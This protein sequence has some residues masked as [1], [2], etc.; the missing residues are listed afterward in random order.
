MID[1]AKDINK[2]LSFALE[3]AMLAGLCYWGFYVGRVWWTGLILGVVIPVL[4]MT[5]WGI[6]LAPKAKRRLKP[7]PGSIASFVLFIVSAAAL[8]NSGLRLAALIVALA[9]A[10]N[11][12]LK[13]A[14]RQW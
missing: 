6:L 7:V 10:L 3:L 9:A 14:W 4:V 1:V 8:S 5:I 11:L 13:L 12:F 2:A